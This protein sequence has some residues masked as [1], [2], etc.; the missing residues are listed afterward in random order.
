LLY[1]DAKKVLLQALTQPEREPTLQELERAW[2]AVEN[3]DSV[4]DEIHLRKLLRLRF[5]AQ[6]EPSNADLEAL[7]GSIR[8]DEKRR[9]EAALA[10][11]YERFGMTRPDRDELEFS[12][13]RET[14]AYKLND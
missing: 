2:Q 7:L 1:R 12:F 4:L 10:R 5:A 9:D 13:L 6:P 3:H 8:A 11:L 14:I